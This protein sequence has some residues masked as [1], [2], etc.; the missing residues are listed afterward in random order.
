MTRYITYGIQKNFELKGL[1][2]LLQSPH[3]TN[4]CG[5]GDHLVLVQEAVG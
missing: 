2:K 1:F 4:V 5:Q 3:E